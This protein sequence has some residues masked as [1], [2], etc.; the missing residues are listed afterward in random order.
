MANILSIILLSAAVIIPSNVNDFL[1]NGPSDPRVTVTGDSYAVNFYFD[2]RNKDAKLVCYAEPGHTV[3]E[4]KKLMLSSPDSFGTYML[5]SVGVNDQDRNTHPSVFK[6][7]LKDI[8]DKAKDRNKIVFVHTY[9]NAPDAFIK[10][11]EFQATDYDKV[12]REFESEYDNVIYI[13][14]SDCTYG[15][16]FLE[17]GYHVNKEFNNLLYDRMMKVIYQIE[18]NIKND[19]RKINKS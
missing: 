14:M 13:D 11:A 5:L 10:G 6:N 16:Y 8:L 17:D 4:N 15:E 18:E 3:E 7:H 2:E 19:K 9:C 1:N 12:L